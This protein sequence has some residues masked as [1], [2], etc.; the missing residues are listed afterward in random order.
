MAAAT[1]TSEL[2]RLSGAVE[3]AA[4]NL[5]VTREMT[6]TSLSWL[7]CSPVSSPSRHAVP[8]REQSIHTRCDYCYL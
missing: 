2:S 3:K 1:L 4:H 6:M 5:L 7:S 8:S